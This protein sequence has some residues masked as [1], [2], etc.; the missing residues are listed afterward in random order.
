MQMIY[1]E[2]MKLGRKVG[3]YKLFV[4]YLETFYLSTIYLR[5]GLFVTFF[6]S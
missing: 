1:D 5:L 2:I 3:R 6:T 4:S